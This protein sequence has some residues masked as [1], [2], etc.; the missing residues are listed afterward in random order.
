MHS[1]HAFL[2]SL[3][4]WPPPLQQLLP[5]CFAAHPLAGPGG[6]VLHPRVLRCHLHMRTHIHM[7]QRTCTHVHTA[8]ASTS[9]VLLTVVVIQNARK[10]LDAYLA[11]A[12]S[13]LCRPSASVNAHAACL[14]RLAAA[15]GRQDL[16][17]HH[18]LLLA[19]ELLLLLWLEPVLALQLLGHHCLQVARGS[20]AYLLH[21]ASKGLVHSNKGGDPPF[22]DGGAAS[23]SAMAS[24]GA[25]ARRGV[26]WSLRQD[27]R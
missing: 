25:A 13:C 14:R 24:G 1:V 6:C 12:S 27:L 20:R 22:S 11:V 26:H 23:W 18:L 17:S 19:A 15:P 5:S 9:H 16:C 3:L 10:S 8:H 2:P 7:Q 4:Q 21:V